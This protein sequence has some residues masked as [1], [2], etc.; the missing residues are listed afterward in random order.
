MHA[1]AQ[2]WAWPSFTTIARETGL[3]RRQSMRAV[4]KLEVQGLILV[5]REGTAH[6]LYRL[7][8]LV[9]ASHQASDSQSP[10]LVT[11]SHPN[12][13]QLNDNQLNTPKPPHGGG[14]GDGF[15]RFWKA[16][17]R[18]LGKQ[19]ASKAWKK[20]QP[21]EALTKTILE[22]IDR[23]KATDGWR[24]A[25]G[26][27]I[28]YPATWLNGKRWEDEIPGTPESTVQT[29]ADRAERIRSARQQAEREEHAARERSGMAEIG[30]Q[31]RNTT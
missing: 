2:G 20:L 9:T 5:T 8:A 29:D 26:Q 3:S 23:H 6:N 10:A 28:P 14:D 24:K 13:N 25:E 11:G 1:D 12:K 4:A 30:R 15:E 22:A 16:Y 21:D 27:Y 7:P 19:D 17:P 31:R 18:R